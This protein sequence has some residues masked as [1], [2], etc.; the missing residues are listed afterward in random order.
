MSPYPTPFKRFLAAFTALIVLISGTF[1]CK[2]GE[3]EPDKPPTIPFEPVKEPPKKAKGTV[4]PVPVKPDIQEEN[5]TDEQKR[6]LRSLGLPV[7][8][9]YVFP[10]SQIEGHYLFP[11]S[12]AK[13]AAE[14]RVFAEQAAS[15]DKYNRHLAK[16]TVEAVWDR[17]RKTEEALDEHTEWWPRNK[18]EVMLGTG[19]VIGSAATILIVFGVN[20]VSAPGQ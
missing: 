2:T 12:K 20:Q 7:G 6:I 13:K 8:D 1:G 5:L 18:D 3:G 16:L 15:N 4:I 17:L 14:L 19:L 10:A 11:E 9:L